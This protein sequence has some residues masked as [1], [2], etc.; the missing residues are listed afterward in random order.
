MKYAIL[1]LGSNIFHLLIAERNQTGI[2]VIYKTNSP[3]KLS[4]N[5]TGENKIIPEAFKRGLN[6]LID[7]KAKINEY[8]IKNIKAIATSAVRSANNGKEFL[9][10]VEK[11]TGI[12]VTLINGRQEAHYVYEGVKASGAIIACSLIIDI[13]G[14][15]TEFILCDEKE[16]FWKQS[17]DI[18]ASRLMQIFFH[19]D[20]LNKANQLALETHLNTHLKELHRQILKYRPSVLI[21]SAGAFETFA[22]M[23]NSKFDLNLPYAVIDFNA[24]RGLA[25]K[26]IQSTHAERKKM[27]NLIALRVDMIVMAAV[28]TNFVLRLGTF[29]KM[30]VSTYDLKM[31]ILNTL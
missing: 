21:G 4:E 11:K 6:C 5:L 22:K 13:G 25:D 9:N 28:Q 1:D 10:T 23:T 17:L 31:G 14:G 15:S 2:Q 24:Y 29:S 16:A 30:M 8:G 12:K 7:F 26:L 27:D 19:S 18:G 20:P 3:V